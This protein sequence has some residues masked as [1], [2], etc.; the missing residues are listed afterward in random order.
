MKPVQTKKESPAKNISPSRPTGGVKHRDYTNVAGATKCKGSI[1]IIDF[2][3]P[4][5]NTTYKASI[6]EAVLNRTGETENLDVLAV[7]SHKKEPTLDLKDVT[8]GENNLPDN[9][10]VSYLEEGEDE[11]ER[12]NDLLGKYAETY[13]KLIKAFTL[14]SPKPKARAGKVINPN[15]SKHADEFL[16]G[17]GVAGIVADLYPN[18]VAD[19]IFD[20]NETATDILSKYFSLVSIDEAKELVLEAIAKSSN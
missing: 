13:L 3:K 12:L 2:H 5:G 20:D 9:F 14:G 19:R 15:N 11:N 16:Y 6:K 10:F 4:K 1:A 18:A 17:N 8:V 7:I